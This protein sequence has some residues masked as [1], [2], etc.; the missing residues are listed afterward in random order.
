MVNMKNKFKTLEELLKNHDWFYQYS[1]DFSVYSS[2]QKTWDTINTVIKVL[3]EAGFS[4]E[5]DELYEKY[6]PEALKHEEDND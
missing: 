1:D 3:E 5:T 4:K 2:G 6:L